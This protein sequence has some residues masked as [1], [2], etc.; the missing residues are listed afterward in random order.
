[1][2]WLTL[3]L[4]LC[5][6]GCRLLFT[7]LARVMFAIVTATN[8]IRETQPYYKLYVTATLLN[9]LQILKFKIIVI[10]NSA[11]CQ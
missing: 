9:D 3:C 2:K 1:M 4:V 11:Q 5:F 8:F 6:L 7:V 10:L